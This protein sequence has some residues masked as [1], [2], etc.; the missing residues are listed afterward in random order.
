MLLP[1]G[2]VQGYFRCSAMFVLKCRDLVP[3]LSEQQELAS[4]L[5]PWWSLWGKEAQGQDLLREQAL[6]LSFWQGGRLLRCC[7][8]GEKT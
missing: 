4:H 1:S 3:Y 8:F 2:T 6:L 5:F 7:H